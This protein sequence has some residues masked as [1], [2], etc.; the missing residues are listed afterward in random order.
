MKYDKSLFA[1]ATEEETEETAKIIYSESD[2]ES[3]DNEDIEESNVN[4]G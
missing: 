2:T 1:T 3:E 4:E